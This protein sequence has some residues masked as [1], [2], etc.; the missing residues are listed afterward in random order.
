MHLINS[1]GL[2]VSCVNSILLD[3]PRNIF[4][5]Y[6]KICNCSYNQSIFL[7]I[8]SSQGVLNK[9]AMVWLEEKVLENKLK[10]KVK[11]TVICKY[12]KESS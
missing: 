4:G 1:F 12:K 8:F 7:S 5:K 11:C 2:K 3:V 10:L 9:D 6:I